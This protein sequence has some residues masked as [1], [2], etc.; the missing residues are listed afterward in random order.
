MDTEAHAGRFGDVLEQIHL[1]C[2]AVVADAIDVTAPSGG[3]EHAVFADPRLQ[4]IHEDVVAPL[5]RVD[6]LE[7]LVGVAGVGGKRGEVVGN[8][9]AV[10]VVPVGDPGERLLRREVDGMG[11]AAEFLGG[12]EDEAAELFAH[13]LGAGRF[14]RPLGDEPLVGAERRDASEAGRAIAEETAA[15][16]FLN[17]WIRHRGGLPEGGQ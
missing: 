10:A 6:E 14:R 8:G 1:A 12:E 7:A 3:A 13:A 16:Q 2:L 9:A 11:S 5:R 4:A 15:G 17:V